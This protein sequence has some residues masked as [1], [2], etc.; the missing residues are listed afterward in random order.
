MGIIYI[1]FIVV[2]FGV[3]ISCMLLKKYK[4]DSNNIWVNN[5][6]EGQC[7]DF[8]SHKLLGQIKLWFYTGN[9]NMYVTFY[10]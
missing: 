10:E 2:F 4:Q 8:N 3:N 7:Y 6:L 5:S 1:W 9:A